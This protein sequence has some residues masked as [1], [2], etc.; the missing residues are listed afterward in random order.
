MGVWGMGLYAGDYAVDVRAAVSAAL[1]L[2]FET[3]R[4]LE[5]LC[6]QEKGVADNESDE[7][8]ATFWLVVADQLARRGIVCDRARDKAL[9][10]IDR[11]QS[12]EMLQRLSA[13]PA[14]IGKRRRML[15]ELRGR[16]VG[17][18]RS[19]SPRKVI[20]K[21]QPLIMQVGDV[22]VYPTSLAHPPSPYFRNRMSYGGQPFVQDGW[23]AA[24][25]VACG[26]VFDF[27]AWYR[28][29][30]I[31][32]LRIEKPD[33]DSLLGAQVWKLESPG[34]CPV[35]HWKRMEIEKI[36]ALA[37]DNG[38]LA[39]MFPSLLPG[40]RA[41]ISDLSLAGELA[42]ASEMYPSSTNRYLTTIADLMRD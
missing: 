1:R 8:Y 33:L 15:E 17:P 26:L 35:L 4:L 12:I 7:D 13:T 21:P 18:M 37:I 32:G 11:D 29:V 31:V 41:A 28:P 25:I 23:G 2:P 3:D 40:V 14:D 38:K 10:I 24:V 16:L 20:T 36:A 22:L 6:E 9:E 42:V 19:P 39:S 27:L 5:V 30:T 34:T